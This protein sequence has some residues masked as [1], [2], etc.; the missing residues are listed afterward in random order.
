MSSG[1][2]ISQDS[3]AHQLIDTLAISAMDAYILLRELLELSKGRGD[4]VKRAQ[5]CV[6]L[7]A[8]ALK[9]AEKSVAFSH[10]VEA[11]LRARG[12]R[13][14]RTIQ[15]IRTVT[16]RLMRLCPELKCKQVRGITPEDCRR[17][18]N[19]CFNTPRQWAK[20]RI[21]LSGV[22]NF[23]VKEGWCSQNVALRLSAPSV[24]ERRI[25]VL[26][27]Y[28]TK[29]LLQSAG[30]LYGG[31]CLPACALMLYAGL[32]P[33]EVRRLTW[34]CIH[35]R[36][37]MVNIEP[38]HSKTGGSRQVK[39]RPV[40]DKL[41]RAYAPEH[42]KNTPLC[43]ANWEKKWRAVRRH[44]GILK[45]TGWIQDVLRHTFASYHQAYFR[46]RRQLEH[47]M[48]H[49]NCALLNNRYLNMDRITPATGKRFWSNELSLIS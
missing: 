19:K 35:L 15:E 17:C 8:E 3:I 11:S 21:I 36:A 48:G 46:N 5:R 13:R 2:D 6:R 12:D 49:S 31:A 44:S 43:P 39:I 27:L 25:R 16:N 40:L 28:E 14:P 41:L 7:G 47:E 18:L 24:R 32:R 45:K 30:R 33:Q 38:Q 26:S 42:R 34:D 23:C 22:L 37:G 1:T 4:R 29:R 10:A 9:D 20:G